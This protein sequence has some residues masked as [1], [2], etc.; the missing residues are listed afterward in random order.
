MKNE[1]NT[2]A[3]S[4]RE[5]PVFGE[6]GVWVKGRVGFGGFEVG[7]EEREGGGGGNAGCGVVVDW[8]VGCCHAGVSDGIL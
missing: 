1:T 5:R 7:G 2:G 6:D 4:G 3:R 8:R